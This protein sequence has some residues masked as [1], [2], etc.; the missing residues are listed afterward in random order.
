MNHIKYLFSRFLHLLIGFIPATLMLFF[1][2]NKKLIIFNS[3]FNECFNHNSKYLFLYFLT[4]RNDFS[5]KFVV[6]DSALRVNLIEEF[7]DYFISTNT[8]KNIFFVLSARTWVTSSLETPVGGFFLSHG[9]NVIHLG[10]GAPIKNIG[11]GEKYNSPFKKVYYALQRTNFTHF[12][13]TSEVFDN[14]WSEC[15]G[16]PLDKVIRSPQARNELISLPAIKSD[17]KSILYAPTWRPFSDTVLFPF[18]DFCLVSLQSYLEKENIVIYLRLHPNFESEASAYS[19]YKNI[20]LLGKAQVPDINE[21]LH[22]FDLL[23]TDYS[24]IYI[25]FLL[26]GSAVLFLPYDLDDYRSS[27]GFTL[28][29][30]SYTPG[31]K[32]CSFIEFLDE[33][34][35]LVNNKDYFKK[36]RVRV[37]ELL[38]PIKHNHAQQS[39]SALMKII[40]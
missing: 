29:Y 37:N 14:A 35:L 40:G 6:N 26:T 15:L 34:G 38:N 19:G 33:I 3:E 32:P 9:R 2:K 30:S 20:Q 24:S 13:S 17:C 22:Q 5:V 28:D 25:D 16:L 10:H 36:E 4:Q 21:K 27:V 31:P 8:I 23:I 12:F 1:P 39:Y 7:G 18:E 11:L